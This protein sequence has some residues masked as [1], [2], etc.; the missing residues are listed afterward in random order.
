MSRRYILGADGRTVQRMDDIVE[1]AFQ[2][3]NLERRVAHDFV[4]AIAISTVFLG[5]DHRLGGDDDSA[6]LVFETMVFDTKHDNAE[7]YTR[8]CS[9]WS[10]A[11]EQHQKAL[12]RV[13]AGE[14]VP[15]P[16]NESSP[17]GISSSG[18]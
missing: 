17:P 18:P 2:F 8:R 9:T 7:L 13:K 14:I 5:I 6:P 10:Q 3:D 4:G 16:R 15:Q 12:D 11:Q 1:W